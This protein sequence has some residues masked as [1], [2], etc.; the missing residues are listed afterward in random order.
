MEQSHGVARWLPQGTSFK[1][2]GY[3][4]SLAIGPAIAFAT[5]LAKGLEET[6]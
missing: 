5:R 3:V 1:A 4:V 2:F 6:R